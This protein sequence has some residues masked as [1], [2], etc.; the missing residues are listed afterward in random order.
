MLDRILVN[1][2]FTVLFILKIIVIIVIDFEGRVFRWQASKVIIY[3]MRFLMIIKIQ[4]CEKARMKYACES[5]LRIT[6]KFPRLERHIFNLKIPHSTSSY[7]SDTVNI[8]SAK[9]FR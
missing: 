4:M 7:H 8:N 1:S 2:K 3:S 6:L 5:F 9:S